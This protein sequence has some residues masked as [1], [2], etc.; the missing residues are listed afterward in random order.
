M[1]ILTNSPFLTR[2]CPSPPTQFCQCQFE[3]QLLRQRHPE[4]LRINCSD[5]LNSTIL[6]NEIKKRPDEFIQSQEKQKKKRVHCKNLTYLNPLWVNSK[7]NKEED[8]N[9]I[10]KKVNSFVPHFLHRASDQTIN[11]N[12]CNMYIYPMQP[13]VVVSNCK[14]YLSPIANCICL[15]LQT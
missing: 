8:V 4:I 3:L 9:P 1:Q 15:Q 11:Q 14:L 12:N 5:L 13:N 7:A 2:G 6:F 10:L